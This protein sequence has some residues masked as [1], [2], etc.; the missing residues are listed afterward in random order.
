[1]ET[2]QDKAQE[3]APKPKQPPGFRRFKRLLER[4]VTT[5]PL[6]KQTAAQ[7]PIEPVPNEEKEN[8]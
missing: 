3:T 1:M 7:A 5:P 8:L 2:N 6:Q 4:I